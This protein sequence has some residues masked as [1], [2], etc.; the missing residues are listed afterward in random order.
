MKWINEY[1]SSLKMAR[2]E[3]LLDLFFYRIIAFLIVKTVYHTRITPNHLTFAAI[4]MGITGGFFYSFGTDRSCI[5]GALFYMM[6]N[7]LDCSDGQ[8]ARLK[9]NGKPIGRII[10]GIA[11]LIAAV[12]IYTGIAV[13]FAKNSNQFP[14]MLILLALSGISIIIQE[15]L[16][17][18][19]R[20]R[21]LDYVLERKNTLAEGN[22]EFRI[23]YDILKNQK[24]KWIDKTI[25]F[26]YLKYSEIQGKLAAK[27]K[28]EKTFQTDSQAY[29]SKNRIIIRFWVLM[30]PTSKITIL[31]LCSFFHRFDIFFWM[32]LGCFNVLAIV[33]SVIQHN[34]DRYFLNSGG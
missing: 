13:G 19:N 11:D 16:V 8:L 29:F 31:I 26:I 3:E 14:L 28:G 5:I 20:T 24:G 7:I 34:I 32:V 22:D 21:F 27:R 2:V 17:D 6:F 30:G 23:E 25:L 15:A 9:G 33:L 4:I 1:K 10:D 18:Y 12:A